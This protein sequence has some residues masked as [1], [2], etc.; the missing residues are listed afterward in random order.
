MEVTKRLVDYFIKSGFVIEACDL[1]M[2]VDRLDLINS[3]VDDHNVRRVYDYL[4]A[5]APFATDTDEYISFLKTAF[6]ISMGQK[7]YPFALRIALRLDDQELIEK[8]FNECDDQVIQKQLAFALGRQRIQVET[9][10]DDLRELMSNSM[11]SEY[12]KKL[13]EDLDVMKPKKPDD[14]Y[15][16]Q[17]EEGVTEGKLESAQANLADTY[18]NAFVNIGTGKDALMQE[19]EPWIANVKKEGIMA[20]TASLGLIYQW[21]IEGCE[22]AITDYL[23][24]KDGY[25]KAGACIGFGISN[26]GIWS[27][28]DP[29]KAILEEYL[30]SESNTVKLGASIGLGIAYAGTAREDFLETLCPIVL[31]EEVGVDTAAYSAVSLGLIFVSRCDEEVVN[32]ILTSL[33]SRSEVE[34]NQP[35]AR[36]FAVGLAL[37]YLGQQEK[38]EPAIETLMA[39][40]HPISEYAQVCVQAAAYIGSGN[41]L[42][43]Q[44]FLKLATP[45]EKTQAKA[46]AQMMAV[47]GIA[48]IA[49]SEDIGNKMA[50]RAMNHI[51]QYSEINV[52]R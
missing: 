15:K 50:S 11:L 41:V 30:E 17:F 46:E 42:K 47:I 49:I 28:L 9:E 2:E 35:V 7:E 43:I 21:D 44:E 10:D 16:Q 36:F 4:V 51:L 27:E 40:E 5:C 33:M 19:K 32:T 13:C 26:S 38:C 6:E 25:A 39:V 8:A 37:T 23:D 34:L 45:H 48:M 22:E 20:A 12:F 24:L 29:A 18:V 14:I 52:K 1:L 3:F 31:D